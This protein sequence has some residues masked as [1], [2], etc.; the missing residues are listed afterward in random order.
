M[1]ISSTIREF[2]VIQICRDT[3]ANW[4]GARLS[5]GDFAEAWKAT[6]L[7]ESDLALALREM[8]DAGVFAGLP[9]S[10]ESELEL[11]PV[12]AE[13][14]AQGPRGLGGFVEGLR[15]RRTLERARRRVRPGPSELGGKTAPRR[16]GERRRAG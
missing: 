16:D 10:M 8:L 12:G 5:I 4:P 6:G 2:A 15:V 13:L 1:E 14:V 11:T 3:R 9:Q 7:R